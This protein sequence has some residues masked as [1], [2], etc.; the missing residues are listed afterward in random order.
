MIAISFGALAIASVLAGC[1]PR[2][3]AP[4]EAFEQA[5]SRG[6]SADREWRTYLGDKAVSHHSKLT[7]INKENVSQLEIEWTYDSGDAHPSGGSQIQFNPLVVKGVLYGVSPSL[8][9]FALDATTG[10]EL[11]SFEPDTSNESWTRSRGVAFWEDG[12]DER[13]LFGAGPH[14]YA[15]DARTGQRIPDFGDGGLV[16]LQEGLG[17]DVGDDMMGVV[18]TTPGTIFE[19]L[20]ILGSRVNEAAGAAPGHLRAFDVRTGKQR[21]IFHTI[22][23]LGEAGHETWPKD[24]WK[25]AGGA[26]SWAGISVDEERGLAFVPTGSAS[27]DFFGGDRAGDNLFAN[28]LVALDARTGERRWHYQFIRH[29]MW[30]RDLPSPPN[31]VEIEH[32]GAT[33]PA[34][35]QVTKTGHTFLFHRET[36]EPLVPMREVPVGSGAVPGEA[37]AKSQPLPEEPPPFVRQGFGMADVGGRTP[38]AAAALRARVE[39]LRLGGAFEPPSPEGTILA[40]G[41]DGGAEWGGAAWDA[42]EGLLFVNA[43]QIVSIIQ[44][45]EIDA[46][47]DLMQTPAVGYIFAC[48]SCHGMDMRGDRGSIPS[49]IDIGDRVGPIDLYDIIM[50]GRGR[51]PGFASMLEPWQAAVIAGWVYFADPEDAPSEWAAQIEG[52]ATFVNAGYQDLR[53]D[54]GVPGSRPPWGTLTAIDLNEKSIRWQVPLGDYP[55]VLATGESGH[56]AEN[57]GGPVLTDSGL[58]FLAATPDAKMRAFDASSGDVLWEADLPAPGFATP[59]TFEA[60]GRQFVVIAAGG[61]KLRQPSSGQYVAF[62]L[63]QGPRVRG[64]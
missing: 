55:K 63:P 9:L 10:E 47:T 28:S 30:D 26:N 7:E 58:L 5:R 64:D 41:M 53:D 32:E 45:L 59:A 56:G 18:A 8:R 39:K 12:D 22:P 11:W 50:E 31:L 43:N 20:L 6:T 2:P 38:A 48:A 57:Y 16:D 37:P 14:L 62:A 52:E 44:M 46:D 42:N 25:T 40:P 21:W 19:D 61:G 34:V 35:A 13:I 15:L 24:A 17:R 27:P 36:G 29:D 23:R 4:S 3:S 49:L 51:M 1:E 33:V 54:D 60:D